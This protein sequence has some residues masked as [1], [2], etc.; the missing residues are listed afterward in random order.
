MD[1][2]NKARFNLDKSWIKNIHYLYPFVFEDYGEK[3][4]LEWEQ[5]GYEISICF[6]SLLDWLKYST[7]L[8]FSFLISIRGIIFIIYSS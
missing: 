4:G 6:I 2:R 8:S 3:C 7:I 1:K 5:S